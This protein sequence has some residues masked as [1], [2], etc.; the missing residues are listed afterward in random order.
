VK[1]RKQ[2]SPA[3]T[4]TSAQPNN[5]NGDE[6]TVTNDPPKAKQKRVKSSPRS[7]LPD[8]VKCLVNLGKPDKPCL[9]C[10]S[11]EVQAEKDNKAKI[12]REQELEDQ[13]I[14]LL[15]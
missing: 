1:G 11:A 14:L 15:A 3:M 4:A 2:K 8:C 5:S 13:K 6:P 7:P 12:A 9:K 10:S